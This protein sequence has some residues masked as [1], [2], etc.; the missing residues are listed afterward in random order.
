MYY[1]ADAR[2]C[3]ILWMLVYVLFCGCSCMYYSADARVCT[4][5]WMLMYVLFCGCSCMYYSGD[6]RVCT[7]LWMLVYVLF[8]GCSCMYYS[9]DASQKI[10][11][12]PNQAT[13]IT[14]CACASCS[15]TYLDILF[16][17]IMF[18]SILL[19]AIYRTLSLQII[20]KKRA[21]FIGKLFSRYRVHLQQGKLLR[22]K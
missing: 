9:V 8:C 17:N 12:L 14:Y 21:S 20:R 5:L 10:K 6:A 16:S 4:I 13:H 2:V 19:P 7:I 11:R 18:H 15:Y 22:F 3:T 1:S